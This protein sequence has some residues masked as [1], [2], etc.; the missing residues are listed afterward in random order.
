MDRREDSLDLPS[1]LKRDLRDLYTPGAS[2]RGNDQGILNAARAAGTR[3][4]GHR[5]WAVGIGVAAAVAIAVGLFALQAG[6][7]PDS[8]GPRAAM[9][10]MPISEPTAT[11]DIR[12]AF[13]V[14]RELKAH[15]TLNQRWD[16]NHDGII[17][18]RDV[19][20]LAVAAVRVEGTEKGDV[21]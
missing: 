21:R 18:T 13:Y 12:D 4:T 15:A 3:R 8:G 14:A 11:G 17:D 5:R 6:H 20:A 16:A 19:Q 9:S 7:V 10:P 2:F 1:E